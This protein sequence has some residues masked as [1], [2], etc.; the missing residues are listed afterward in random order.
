MKYSNLSA[1]THARLGSLTHEE[2]G[3][4]AMP[5]VIDGMITDRTSDDV[6]RLAAL[7]AKGWHNLTEGE[8]EEYLTACLRGAYNASDLNRVGMAL[9]FVA[10][11]LA[12][13]GYAVRINASTGW[14]Q[15]DLF[16]AADLKSYLEDV[17]RL[18]A[19]L[20][21]YQTTPETPDKVNHY[22]EANAVEQIICDV[23]ELLQKMIA[24]YRYCNTFYSGA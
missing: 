20:A 10:E 1:Y 12:A 13:W 6:R 2:I 16:Y 11:A 21:A 24:G 17:E 9:H 3:S 4:C 15:E 23:Y 14:Q 18:R 22:T 7:C 19:R 5:S 8:R